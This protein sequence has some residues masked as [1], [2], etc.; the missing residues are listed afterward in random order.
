MYLFW[1]LQKSSQLLIFYMNIVLRIFAK[2]TL[3]ASDDF[4]SKWKSTWSNVFR[5]V[6]VCIFW[7]CIQ[8]TI[9]WDKTQILKKFPTD[10]I[11]STRNVLF[12]LSRA[13]SHQSFT[14]SLQSLY[15]LKGK[16]RLSKPLCAI[17]HFRFPFAF[18]KVYSFV[19]QNASTLWL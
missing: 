13:P 18:I 16:I 11:N 4:K 6:K 3:K 7:K 8:Y 15:E 17:I 14:F 2:N 10:K 19:Q 12:F 1:R 5:Y 9:H